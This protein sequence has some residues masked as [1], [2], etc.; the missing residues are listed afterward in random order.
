MRRRC[1]MHRY[2]FVHHADVLHLRERGGPAADQG[3]E[4]SKDDK[5]KAHPGKIGMPVRDEKEGGIFSIEDIQS[6]GVKAKMPCIRPADDA[7]LPMVEVPTQNSGASSCASS[8]IVVQKKKEDAAAVA[9]SRMLS[10]VL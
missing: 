9:S 1:V 10:T 7:P 8:R 6:T 3:A 5:C 4:N 2:V